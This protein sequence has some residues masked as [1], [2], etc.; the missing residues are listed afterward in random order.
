M[1]RSGPGDPAWRRF[2]A[3]KQ[4]LPESERSAPAGAKTV[5]T[6]GS[7][8]PATHTGGTVGLIEPKT[9]HFTLEA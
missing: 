4:M 3:V 5:H 9:V 6:S 1:T 2:V 8:S 7:P